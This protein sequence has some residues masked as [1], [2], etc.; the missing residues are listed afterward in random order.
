MRQTYWYRMILSRREGVVTYG[1]MACLQ[2]GKQK[3]IR[4]IEDITD[5]LS[6]ANHLLALIMRHRVDPVS[7]QGVVEDFLES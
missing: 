6:S 1:V 2:R 5:D 7:L 3:E 4:A